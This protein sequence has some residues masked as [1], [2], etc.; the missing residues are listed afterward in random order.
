MCDKGTEASVTAAGSRL[1]G[2]PG[3]NIE[4]GHSMT[5]TVRAFVAIELP[6]EVRRALSE[7]QRRLGSERDRS[8]K[9][10]APEGIHLTL[11]FFGDVAA[12]QVPA[13]PAH[14]A[15]PRPARRPYRSAWPAPAASRTWTAQG[16]SGLGLGGDTRALRGCSERWRRSWPG[17]GIDRRHGPFRLT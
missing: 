3:L 9:W 6:P 4:G 16:C 5:G 2:R 1:A 7:M 10:V 8:A 12:E 15:G 13:S 17:W 14:L 11:H